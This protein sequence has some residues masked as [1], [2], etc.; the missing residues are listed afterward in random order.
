MYVLA[1]Y[2]QNQPVLMTDPRSTSRLLVYTTRGKARRRARMEALRRGG[3]YIYILEATHGQEPIDMLL[4]DGSVRSLD[5][6]D[7]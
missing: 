1:T 4:P 7:P 5:N 3:T 2:V 6:P